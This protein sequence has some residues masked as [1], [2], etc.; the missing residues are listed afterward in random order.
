[1]EKSRFF[2]KLICALA[3]APLKAYRIF[4]SP[5]L[6]ALFGPSCGCRY[7]PTCSHYAE[8]AIKKFGLRQGFYLA[9]QRIFRCHP[10]GANGYDPVPNSLSSDK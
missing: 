6:A 1:M 9:I 4:A 8:Q 10:W 5:L 2:R 3:L 7:H